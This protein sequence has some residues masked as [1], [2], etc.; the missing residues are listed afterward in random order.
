[1]D[2]RGKQ[3]NRVDLGLSETG[4]AKLSA[5]I[6]A[7]TDSQMFCHIICDIAVQL[8][9]VLFSTECAKAIEPDG[10]VLTAELKNSRAFAFAGDPHGYPR[11]NKR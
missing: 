11:E 7:R 5:R 10:A 4:G 1:M 6:D 8:G 9:C 3:G 2:F